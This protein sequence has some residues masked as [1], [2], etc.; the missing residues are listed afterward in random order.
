[1]A[2]LE[3]LVPT[4]LGKVRGTLGTALNL[5]NAAFSLRPP[6]EATSLMT[7]LEIVSLSNLRFWSS[8]Q[9]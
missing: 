3:N 4:I 9:S 1:M 2:D 5:A 7:D 6:E 8:L